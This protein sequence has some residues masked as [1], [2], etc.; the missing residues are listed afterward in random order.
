M[1]DTNNHPLFPTTGGP[2]DNTLI[3]ALDDQN[4]G[5]KIKSGDNTALKYRLR[6]GD[7]EKIDLEGLPCTAVLKKGLTDTYS[8]TDVTIDA[9]NVAKFK[10][11]TVLPPNERDPYIVE[12]IVQDGLNRYIFPSD[13]ELRL[14]VYPSQV[15]DDNDFVLE[16]AENK[17]EEIVLKT[18]K[19][20]LDR[21]EAEEDV[22]IQSEDTRIS[23]EN[24][25]K[26]SESTRVSNENTRQI[27]ESAR[28]TEESSRVSAED[29]R[30]SADATWTANEQSRKD[31]ESARASAE[32]IRKSKEDTRKANEAARASAEDTRKTNETARQNNESTREAN[33][34]IVEGWIANPSQFNG[35]DLEFTWDGT[36]LGVRQQGDTTYQYVDLK[37][38][39]GSLENLTSQHVINALGYTPET[40]GGA[41]TKADT[42]ESNANTYTD[43]QIANIPDGVVVDGLSY[44]AYTAPDTPATFYPDEIIFVLE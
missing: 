12:F 19:P 43:N 4:Y 37:G 41:Q 3:N 8:T 25:R 6:D 38:E 22:R 1:P 32:S 29:A 27:N 7:G 10:I 9:N 14:Y 13:N 33:R 18:A 31:N 16:I 26:S 5:N 23:N 39:T 35:K 30:A 28:Q 44:T 36:S 11:D 2:I 24:T 21:V 17:L 20:I 34:A 42:A 15:S 40:T